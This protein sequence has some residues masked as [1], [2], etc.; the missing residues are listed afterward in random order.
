A[1][2]TVWTRSVEVLPESAIVIRVPAIADASRAD[3]QAP[4]RPSRI[5]YGLVIAAGASALAS[6]SL[7][8]YAWYEM[9]HAGAH[10]HGRNV[11]TSQPYCDPEGVTLLHRA[12]TIATLAT[13]A[14]ITSLVALGTGAV[15]WWMTR[16]PSRSPTA[17]ELGPAI[18]P[19]SIGASIS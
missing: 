11:D 12:S 19:T 8:G 1:G 2:Q 9:S 7:G 15:I 6:A 3:R 10:C 13:G 17:I 4:R 14:G 18:G 5:A 16:T